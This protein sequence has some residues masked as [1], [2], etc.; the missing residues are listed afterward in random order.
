MPNLPQPR[1]TVTLSQAFAEL[2]EQTEQR[3]RDDVRAPATLDMQR[4]HRR[5]WEGRLG[6]D[7]PL[8]QVDELVLED[9]ASRR[10]P[11]PAR[12]LRR[13]WGPATL[14]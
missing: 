14:R 6:P 8:D 2:L 10:P 4:A 12:G 7:T 1:Q 3:V 11:K 13:P 9:V 5:W